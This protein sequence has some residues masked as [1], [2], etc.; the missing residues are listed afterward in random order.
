M[1]FIAQECS[2]IQNV[3]ACSTIMCPFFSRE[4]HYYYVNS[5]FFSVAFEKYDDRIWLQEKRIGATKT[6]ISGIWKIIFSNRWMR[7]SHQF[8]K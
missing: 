5:L 2:V 1:Y 6:H 3:Q 4:K 8:S 7:I